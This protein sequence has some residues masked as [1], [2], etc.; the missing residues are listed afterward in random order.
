MSNRIKIGSTTIDEQAKFDFNSRFIFGQ[1]RAKKPRK[2]LLIQSEL[3]SPL[4]T[5]RLLLILTIPFH[6]SVS[7]ETQRR[8][9]FSRERLGRNS[10]ILEPVLTR[11]AQSLHLDGIM[12]NLSASSDT[13]NP[14]N[15]TALKPGRS[16][17]DWIKLT[18][19]SADLSGTGNKLKDI[20]PDELAQ[21]N[22]KND[23]WLAIRGSILF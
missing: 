22:N 18:N 3:R 9:G 12:S 1:V 17:M 15:K 14:R 16:L 7:F 20:S 5:L 6:R 10:A 19:S 21:H 23:A 8:H 2:K 11:L 13:G 4:S